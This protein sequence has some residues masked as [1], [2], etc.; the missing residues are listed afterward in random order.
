MPL[1]LKRQCIAGMATALRGCN[2]VYSIKYRYRLRHILI[3]RPNPTHTRPVYLP[4]EALQVG[5]LVVEFAAGG[6]LTRKR[7]GL[8]RIV[9]QAQAFGRDLQPKG[10]ARSCNLGRP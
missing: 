9:G 1:F 3:P 6:L 4:A 2:G 10:W 8:A 7:A 5:A